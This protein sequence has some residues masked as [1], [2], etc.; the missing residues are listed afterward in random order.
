MTDTMPLTSLMWSWSELLGPLTYAEAV[1]I[2]ILGCTGVLYIVES[3]ASECVDVQQAVE[4]QESGW[5]LLLGFL[6]QISQPQ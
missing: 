3:T 1:I 5:S 2:Y 6:Y 4:N